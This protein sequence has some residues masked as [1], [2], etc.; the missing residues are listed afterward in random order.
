MEDLQLTVTCLLHAMHADSIVQM[1]TSTD[2][3]WSYHMVAA[4]A[5]Q[6]FQMKDADPHALH[7]ANT[8]Q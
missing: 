2:H 3:S 4:Q 1:L 5:A 6:M 7:A 8:L